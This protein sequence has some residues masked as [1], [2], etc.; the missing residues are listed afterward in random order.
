MAGARSRHVQPATR[1]GEA[2]LEVLDA[3]AQLS[4]LTLDVRGCIL[5]A[6]GVRERVER[7]PER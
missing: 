6:G 1:C 2:V 3:F 4:D 7:S 5:A